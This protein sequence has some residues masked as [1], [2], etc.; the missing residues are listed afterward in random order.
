MSVKF[1]ISLEEALKKLEVK[2]EQLAP[3]V[4]QEFNQAIQ[5]LAY[6]THANIVAKAQTELNNTRQDYLKDLEFTKLGDNEFLISLKGGWSNQIEHGYPAYSL[7]DKLLSSNKTVSVGSRAGQKWVQEGQK[8][9]KYAHVPFSRQ[10]SSKSGGGGDLAES[11]Q[12]MKAVNAQGRKQKITKIFK[13]LEGNALEGKV[14]TGRSN[15]PMLDNLVK[16][17][18]NYKNKDT[19]KVTTQSV[20]INYRTISELGKDWVH[21]GYDGL[22]AF[23]D[24]EKYALDQLDR[25]VKIVLGGS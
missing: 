8:E 25:I 17:Q 23:E 14:A 2:F 5:D 9:Q 12:R 3:A 1:E 21:P 7:R 13:D 4:E 15:N 24:A 22:K 6:A 11:I 18:K 16:Y 19:G 20:Y 10:P